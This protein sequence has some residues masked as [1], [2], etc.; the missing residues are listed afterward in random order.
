M[1]DPIR[2][3]LEAEIKRATSR[4]LHDPE[5]WQQQGIP[6][7][8]RYKDFAIPASIRKEADRGE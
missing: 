5:W 6:M 2:F 3:Y 7:P 8:D 1:S 4:R